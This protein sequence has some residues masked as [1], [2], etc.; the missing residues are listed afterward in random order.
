MTLRSFFSQVLDAVIKWA[1]K[2]WFESKLEA[3]LKKIEWDHQRQYYW[4]LDK[5]FEPVYREYKPKEPDSEAAKLGGAMRLTSKWVV[6][7]EK[8]ETEEEYLDSYR[9]TDL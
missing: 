2:L 5:D 3:R 4:D 8:Y 1:K 9:Q 6:S 7:G